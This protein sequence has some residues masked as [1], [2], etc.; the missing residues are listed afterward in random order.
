MTPF[1]SHP[2]NRL[3]KTLDAISN[4]V[5][6][7]K[8]LKFLD[9][10]SVEDS[11]VKLPPEKLLRNM[12]FVFLQHIYDLADYDLIELINDRIS[13]KIFFGLEPDD[14]F[15]DDEA[16]AA[17]RELLLEKRLYTPLINF[18]WAS[19]EISGFS[20]EKGV[21]MDA[22]IRDTETPAPKPPDTPHEPAK[23]PSPEL[24]ISYDTVQKMIR[25][26][27]AQPFETYALQMQLHQAQKDVRSGALSL[28]EATENLYKLCALVLTKKKPAEKSPTPPASPAPKTTTPH[29]L[30]QKVNHDLLR[31]LILGEVHY[32]FKHYA[33]QMQ[34]HQSQKEVRNGVI[35]LDEATDNL[36]ELCKRLLTKQLPAHKPQVEHALPPA[37]EPPA[38]FKINREILEKMIRGE[39]NQNF[40]HYAL[41]M[42]LHQA[43]KEVGSG[44]CSIDEAVEKLYDL[45]KHVLVHK[46]YDELTHETHDTHETHP[47]P[48][49]RKLP[50]INRVEW[51]KLVTGE[52]EHQF[53]NYVLQVQL[54]QT[55]KEVR[56]GKL[57]VERA[58]QN[59]YNLCLRVPL[60]VQTDFKQIFKEW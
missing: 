38:T 12:K 25:G 54:H 16:S 59:L 11:I 34:L 37:K 3:T 8:V 4:A 33:L 57:S 58:V 31:K 51:K 1:N 60:A 21:I 30:P 2:P 55:K 35:S 40:K 7:D 43:K 22:R 18:I 32:H 20:I 23:H 6:W 14:D 15:E 19:L 39:L 10:H 28:D 44:S 9:E 27:I 17:F 26:E 5:D 47:L 46:P 50:D 13:F 29:A 52:L 53:R 49:H 45:C 56:S 36:Y 24:H 41:Q 48:Q 42:Q